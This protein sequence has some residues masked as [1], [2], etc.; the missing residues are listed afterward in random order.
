[1]CS[2]MYPTPRQLRL[3]ADVCCVPPTRRDAGNFF[4][5]SIQGKLCSPS[6]PGF[7]ASS[8]T[9]SQ[10]QYEFCLRAQN[11]PAKCLVRPCQPQ[12]D[13]ESAVG[14]TCVA[15]AIS[16]WRATMQSGLGDTSCAVPSSLARLAQQCSLF[17]DVLCMLWRQVPDPI[18]RRFTEEWKVYAP[19]Y[20]GAN[21]T[22][23]YGF[24]DHEFNKVRHFNI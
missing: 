23:G 12:I 21:S 20:V 13:A 19:G 14:A 9:F 5:C 11:G 1:M 6:T 22:G 16:S 18:I 8:P 15:V 2:Y 7:N 3:L 4:E 17:C 10:S 24:L